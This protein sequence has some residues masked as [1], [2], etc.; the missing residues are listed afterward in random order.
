MTV[1]YSGKTPL[2]D[3]MPHI[4]KRVLSCF[5]PSY[6]KAVAPKEARALCAQFKV[7]EGENH[8]DTVANILAARISESRRLGH[9]SRHIV[10][11]SLRNSCA[12][13]KVT[14]A[15]WDAFLKSREA[16]S[17]GK[18]QE[19]EEQQEAFSALL[20]SVNTAKVAE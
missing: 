1:K 9:I 20:K 12:P 18:V 6:F 5:H 16:K 2:I 17:D 15:M 14:R 4:A 7:K 10:T 13:E 3:S 19:N 8:A 11:L